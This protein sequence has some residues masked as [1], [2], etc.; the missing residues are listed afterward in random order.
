MSQDTDKKQLTKTLIVRLLKTHIL[1][2]SLIVKIQQNRIELVTR[3][4]HQG[5]V[6]GLKDP[7]SWMRKGSRCGVG[8]C[9]G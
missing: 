4:A 2:R 9:R 5:R 8:T 1:H 3:P 6:P 7:L